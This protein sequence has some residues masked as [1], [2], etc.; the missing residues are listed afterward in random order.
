MAGM[1]P[2]ELAALCSN[3]SN[4]EQ[5]SMGYTTKLID[6]RIAKVIEYS[7]TLAIT[8]VIAEFG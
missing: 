1:T 2:V 3:E 4:A 7:I 5:R 8:E 6:Y